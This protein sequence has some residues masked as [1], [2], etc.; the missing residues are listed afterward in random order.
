MLLRG[1]IFAMTTI[2][3][4]VRQNPITALTTVIIVITLTFILEPIKY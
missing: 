4:T 2:T 1:Q 3:V